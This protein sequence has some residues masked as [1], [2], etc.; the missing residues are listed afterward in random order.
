MLLGGHL[1]V[2]GEGCFFFFNKEQSGGIQNVLGLNKPWPSAVA[3]TLVSKSY[4]DEQLISGS[5][6]VVL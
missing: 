3:H 1:F 5:L 4:K 6:N 2:C